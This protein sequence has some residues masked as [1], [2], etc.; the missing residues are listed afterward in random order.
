VLESVAAEQQLDVA[1]ISAA[2]LLNRSAQRITASGAEID[3][4]APGYRH[5]LTLTC[6]GE[7]TPVSDTRPRRLS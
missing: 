1:L 3:A 2:E 4:P 6:V 5:E 7:L